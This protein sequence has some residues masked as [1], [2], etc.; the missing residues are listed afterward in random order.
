MSVLTVTPVELH[1]ELGS[2]KPPKLLDV[3]EEPELA[4]SKLP[5]DYHIPLRMLL[6]RVVEL[7][8]EEDLVVYCRSGARSASATA[9]LAKRGFRRVR[10][11]ET[12][13]NGWARTVDATMAIY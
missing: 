12:G 7:N 13:I 9:F 5:N 4:I 3:R 10:N 6:D 11:L 1:E 8:P 2:S